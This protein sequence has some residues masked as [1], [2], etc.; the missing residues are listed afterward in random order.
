MDKSIYEKYSFN[1]D[2]LINKDIKL[3]YSSIFNIFTIISN[4][5]KSI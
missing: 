5:F 1:F 3:K 4:G 2:N